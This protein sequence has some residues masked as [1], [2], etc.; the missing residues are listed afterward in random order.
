M[1]YSRKACTEAAVS[2]RQDGQE[3]AYTTLEKADNGKGTDIV[4]FDARTGQK[5]ILVP[6][7]SLIPAGSETPLRIQDYSWSADGA[8][9]LI[10]TNTKRVWQ[11]QYT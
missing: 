4:R 7:S 11:V 6:A 9:L 8:R 5:S 1:I 3:R 2:A 10:F